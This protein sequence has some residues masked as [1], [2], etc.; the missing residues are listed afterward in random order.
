MNSHQPTIDPRRLARRAVAALEHGPTVLLVRHAERE[1]IA[2]ATLSAAAE[3]PLTNQGRAAARDLGAMLPPHHP[4]RLRFSPVP[5]CEDTARNIALGLPEQSGEVLGPWP[6]LGGHFIQ[7]PE[8][9]VKALGRR[10]LRH[11]VAAWFRGEI[12]EGLLLDAH[13]GARGLLEEL[14]SAARGAPEPPLD[15]QV[16]HDLIVFTLLGVAWD[17]SSP[18]LPWPGFL[19]GVVIDCTADHQATLW[20]HDQERTVPLP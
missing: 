16:S 8:K 15:I 20:Y 3:A 13:Q 11:F 2:A 14:V 7:E 10:D 17:L 12:G 6:L 18:E 9:L 19:D 1:R 4:T 5:R